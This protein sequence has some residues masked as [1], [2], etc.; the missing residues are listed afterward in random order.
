MTVV[1]FC[2]RTMPMLAA[3]EVMVEVD[4]PCDVSLSAGVDPSGIGGRGLQRE[5]RTPGTDHPVVDGWLEWETHGGLTRAGAAYTTVFEGRDASKRVESADELAPLKTTYS[6]RAL[7]GE[8]CRLRQLTASVPSQMHAYPPRQ[9]TRLAAAASERGF[10]G[11]RRENRDAW[12][13]IWR[14]RIVLEGADARWQGYA[15]AACYYLHASAHA[16]SLF[17]TSMF[18]LAYWPNYHYYEGHVMWDIEAFA[19]PPLLLTA[20]EV[21]RALLEYRFLRRDAAELNAAMYGYEGLQFPWASGPLRGEE[22]IRTNAPLLAFEQHVSPAVAN[23][24]VDFAHA[25]A[26]ADFLDSH[27]WPVVN[28]VAGWILSRIRHTER[29]YEVPEAIGPAEQARPQ[30][31]NVYMNLA[32]AGLLRRGAAIARAAGRH[33]NA[34]LWE[35]IAR[36][37]YLP[38][39]ADGTLLH[40]DG[41]DRE[42]GGV[43]NATPEALAGLVLFGAPLP[44]AAFEATLRADLD[45]VEPYLGYPMLNAPLGPAAAWLGDRDRASRLLEAGYAEYVRGPYLET[46]EY[47]RTRYPDRAEAGPFMANIG[48][49]LSGLL[50]WLPRIRIGP[51][52]PGG[53]RA[54]GSPLAMPSLWEGIDAQR[55]VIHGQEAAIR[56]RHGE[57]RARIEFG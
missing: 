30:D 44:A 24:F 9:A 42:A 52:D 37:F 55:V 51:G 34:E 53:W 18:G 46:D 57:R 43:V 23:A 7:P 4:T 10:D 13:A 20:P 17:S 45:R 39:A 36:E 11:L 32:C 12:Q 2:P 14:G 48:G 1:A 26:D 49:F 50:L 27:A 3:Q 35:R 28:G 19:F 31:N 29:G 21:A 16:S 41:F 54:G 33:R 47:S 40:H 15:D 56:A 5:T 22:A 38:R 25:T 8:R 6:Y